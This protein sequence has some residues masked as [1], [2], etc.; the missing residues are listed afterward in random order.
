MGNRN[1]HVTKNRLSRQI[2]RSN[3]KKTD[4]EPTVDEAT[5]FSPSDQEGEDFREPTVKRKRKVDIKDRLIEHV[6][7]N[8]HMWAIGAFVTLGGYFLVDSKII[9][10]RIDAT[11]EAHKSDISRIELSEKEDSQKNQEQDMLLK[12]HAIRLEHIEKQNKR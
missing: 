9:I 11:M 5:I 6:N 8:W 4:Y 3:I 1:S 2:Y 7:N 10:A 12:E